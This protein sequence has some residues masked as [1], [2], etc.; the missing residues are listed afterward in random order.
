M[1]RQAR[2]LEEGCCYYVESKGFEGRDI[3]VRTIDF[4]YYLRL[5]KRFKMKMNVSIYGF[6]LLPKAVCLI[7]HPQAD[8]LSMFMQMINQ[9]YALYF[10]THHERKGKVWADRFKSFPIYTDQDLFECIKAVEFQPVKENL[11][12]SPVQYKWSSCT[13]RVLGGNSVV[14]V[15]SPALDIKCQTFN[16]RI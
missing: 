10:N 6:C 3:F 4:Q 15:R 5:V 9:N 14:D 11:A 16:G 13:Y 1:I 7:A 8:G 12:P 2:F